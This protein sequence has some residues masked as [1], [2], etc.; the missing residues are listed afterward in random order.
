VPDAGGNIKGISLSGKAGE[1]L[2][3]IKRQA[4]LDEISA[5]GQEQKMVGRCI[6]CLSNDWPTCKG[7]GADLS[8]EPRPN[9]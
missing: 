7:C 6:G 8:A 4:L 9:G 2:D 3:R 1:V 5:I